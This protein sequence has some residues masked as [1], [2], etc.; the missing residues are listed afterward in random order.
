[1]AQIQSDVELLSKFG[2]V[3]YSLKIIVLT[4]NVPQSRYV[5]ENKDLHG[6]SSKSGHG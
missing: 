5:K 6:P 3:D 2:L 4:K 1:M